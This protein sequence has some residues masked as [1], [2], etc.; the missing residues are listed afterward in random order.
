MGKSNLFKGR[1]VCTRGKNPRY[2]L[3]RSWS[4]SGHCVRRGSFTLLAEIRHYTI[5]TAFANW[6]TCVRHRRWLQIYSASQSIP[7]CLQLNNV[8]STPSLEFKLVIL[9]FKCTICNLCTCS[10]IRWR[11]TLTWSEL[12][13]CLQLVIWRVATTATVNVRHTRIRRTGG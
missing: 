5:H 10:Q 11:R 3:Y 6:R 8:P 2:P 9:H 4:V 7:A 13:A 12:E 1:S